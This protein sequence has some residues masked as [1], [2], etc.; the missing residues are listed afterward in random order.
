MMIKFTDDALEA[1]AELA[2]KKKTGARAL[3]TI[4]EEVLQPI[5]YILPSKAPN[6]RVII[7]RSVVLEG[8]EP[9]IVGM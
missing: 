7:D 3:R 8:A 2:I 4:L 5:L 1:I 6:K 9:Q